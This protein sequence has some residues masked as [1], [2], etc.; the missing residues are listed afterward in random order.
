MGTANL[1]QRKILLNDRVDKAKVLGAFINGQGIRRKVHEVGG[2]LQNLDLDVIGIAETWLLPGE[3]VEVDGYRWIGIPR[4][5]NV[6]RGGWVG[7]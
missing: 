4:E 7:S 2:I 3:R 6:G 1:H 5:G